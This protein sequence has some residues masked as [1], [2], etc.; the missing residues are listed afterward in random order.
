MSMFQSS[1]QNISSMRF[2]RSL[3]FD[4]I[5]YFTAAH[6]V[7]SLKHWVVLHTVG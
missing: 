3:Q 1:S 2:L 6:M 7:L 4:P 5:M